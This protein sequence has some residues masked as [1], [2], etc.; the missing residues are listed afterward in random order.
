MLKR[1]YEAEAS[2]DGRTLE[3]VCVPYGTAARV[4]D[5]DGPYLEAF[6]RGAFRRVIKAPNRTELRY[7]HD[8]S[9]LPYGFGLQLEERASHLWGSFS[10]APTTMGEQLLALVDDGLTGVSIGF[11]PGASEVRD[12]V[13]VRTS[14]KQLPEVSLTVAA[15]YDAAMVVAVRSAL[16]IDVAADRER[17]RLR[18]TIRAAMRYGAHR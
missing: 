1:T 13:T 7:Q 18:L 6:Q 12:G 10:V 16:G 8:G 14:V 17:E 3:L 15:S 9:G 4:D 11:V 5:G 2:T